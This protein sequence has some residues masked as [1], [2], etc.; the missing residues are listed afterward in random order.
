MKYSLILIASLILSGFVF[1]PAEAQSTD[2]QA[3]QHIAQ[4]TQTPE[5][6]AIAQE[7][8][9]DLATADFGAAI[10]T[11]DTGGAEN[12]TQSSLTQTWQDIVAQ[13]GPLQQQVDTQLEPGEP[14]NG[15]TLVIIT[16]EFERECRDLFVIMEETGEVIGLDVAN[17]EPLDTCQAN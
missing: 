15:P 9:N 14:S 17:G 11:F 2:S 5:Y 7:F 12:V 3:S 4:D 16:G 1:L 13:S 6:E 10:Q 8:I